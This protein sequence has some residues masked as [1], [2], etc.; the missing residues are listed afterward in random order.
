MTE[1]AVEAEAVVV[2]AGVADSIWIDM[3]GLKKHVLLISSI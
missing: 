3:V 2:L 1:E